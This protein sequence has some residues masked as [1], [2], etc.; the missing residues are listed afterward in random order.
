MKSLR[1]LLALLALLSLAVAPFTRA[2][3][4]AVLFWNDQA[5]N[6][7][8]LARTPP[9]IASHHLATVHAAIH[10][11][12]A[13]IT[14]THRPWQGQ[15][16]ARAGASL[17]AA[18]A[19]SA[20]TVINALWGQA[21]NPENY[22][23]AYAQALAAIP[24]GPA[25]ADGLAFGKQVAEAVLA[26]RAQSGWNKPI[27]GTFSSTEPGLW[28]ET[29]PGFRPPVLP[30]WA[31]V[32]PFVMKSP[33]QFRAPPPPA[34]NSKQAA[35]EMEQIVRIGARDNADRTEYQTLAAPFWADDLGS[36]TPPGHWNVIAQ[37]LTRRN[38]LS[39][40]DT[41]RF[42]ALLNLAL[43]DAGITIWETKFHYRTWRPETSIRE[44]TKDINPHAIAHPD[45][46]PLMASPAFPSYISGHSTFSAAG[47]RLIE[48]WF[49]TDDIEFTTTSDGLPGAVRTFKKLSECRD[50]IGM[51]RLWGGIHV[52]ADNVEGQKAGIKV[53]DYVFANALQPVQK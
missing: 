37:D 1:P 27:E 52:M 31:K 39:T 48:R 19:S 42:F 29:P 23:R 5:L 10:D 4:N 11:S 45:F 50:E 16:I 38:K 20:F 53:A 25:K 40:A 35:D 22:R 36:A 12:V 51:S 3:D 41:A 13:G 30:H 21:A 33:D 15:A 9:P 7:I 49:G 6:A 32:V 44:V 24:E 17:D 26:I 14:R 18:I 46:I 2:A 47:S 28:R 8:R 34:V 43:A